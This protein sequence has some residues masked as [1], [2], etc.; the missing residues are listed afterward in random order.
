MS[1][2]RIMCSASG[3]S[4]ALNMAFHGRIAVG[5]PSAPS[6]KPVGPFI[7]ALAATTKNAEATPATAIGTPVHQCTR[8]GSRSH[9]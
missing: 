9:P 8:G 3:N 5:N 6:V 4:V 7:Q 1:A 2:A